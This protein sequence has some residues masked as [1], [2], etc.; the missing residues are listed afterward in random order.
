MVLNEIVLLL[1]PLIDHLLGAVRGIAELRADITALEVE[2]AA[3]AS[4]GRL[5]AGAGRQTH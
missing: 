1:G 5:A 3:L 2:K 4:G